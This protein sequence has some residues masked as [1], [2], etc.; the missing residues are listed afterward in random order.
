MIN[1]DLGF[2]V[3]CCEMFNWQQLVIRVLRDDKHL[4]SHRDSCSP[5]RTAEAPLPQWSAQRQGSA[6]RK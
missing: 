3:S 4:Y 2:L 5:E 6:C 1:W